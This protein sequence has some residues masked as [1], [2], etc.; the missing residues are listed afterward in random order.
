[1]EKTKIE[2]CDSTW[3]PVTGCLH[4]CE[5]CYARKI[6]KR[7]GGWNGG[8]SRTLV[9]YDHGGVQIWALENVL[10]KDGRVAPY[11][12]GFEPTLYR[13]KLDEPL[14]KKKPQTIF[15]CSMADL[16]GAW[17][18]DSWIEEVLVACEK[19]PQH[20]YLFL[21]KN[22]DRYGA[23]AQAGK[24][25]KRDNMWYG[26][27]LDS[28][29]ARRYPGRICDNTFVSI[30]PLTERMDVGLGS[31]GRDRWAII[32]AE[33]GNRKGKVIPKKE[34]IN[35]ICKAADLTHAA[36]FMK[37]SLIPIVG[38]ENMRREFPWQD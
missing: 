25:P 38:E 29:K 12:C 4:G 32:G 34:W 8:N 18:P 6:A 27:T 10:E 23:L 33:T 14:R 28:M 36:V 9:G 24:L 13:Y 7:F 17:V 21:T 19:A 1:M 11:P 22:P 5:Y 35:S 16:F 3:N 30:E 15:V 20:R 2:W 37:D 31:F 26:S